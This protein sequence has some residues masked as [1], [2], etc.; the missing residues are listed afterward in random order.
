[1]QMNLLPMSGKESIWL[2]FIFKYYLDHLIENRN[3]G[4]N[5]IPPSRKHIS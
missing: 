4:I 2:W 1:M 5:L 3:T